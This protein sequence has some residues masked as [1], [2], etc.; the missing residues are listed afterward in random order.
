MVVLSTKIY[1]ILSFLLLYTRVP[2]W[3]LTI[4]TSMINQIGTS[5]TTE[6][7]KNTWSKNINNL[8][9]QNIQYFFFYRKR[10]LSHLPITTHRESRG[11]KFIF[12]HLERLY[13]VAR[14]YV[15]LLRSFVDNSAKCCVGGTKSRLSRVT[16][17]SVSALL[18]LLTA[19]SNRRDRR[20]S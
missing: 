9:M 3:T 7:D 14:I 2:L 11:A 4:S 8:F 6:A 19:S 1:N 10:S 20:G 5:K 16:G 12:Y 18:P 17:S 15:P 13:W